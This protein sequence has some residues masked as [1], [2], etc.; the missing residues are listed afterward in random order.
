MTEQIS[1]LEDIGATMDEVYQMSSSS[2]L[3]YQGGTHADE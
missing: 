2:Q 3:E 1:A